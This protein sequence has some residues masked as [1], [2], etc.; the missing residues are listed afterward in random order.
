[1]FKFNIITTYN[2]GE[3]VFFDIE[4]D[5]EDVENEKTFYTRYLEK[6]QI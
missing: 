2:D 3:Q 1:M 4:M 5:Q 6:N